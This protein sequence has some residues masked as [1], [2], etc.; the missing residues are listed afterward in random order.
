MVAYDDSM[1][2]KKQ[3]RLCETNERHTT[4]YNPRDKSCMYWL[5]AGEGDIAPSVQGVTFLGD[6][7]HK[8][9]FT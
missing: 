8:F 2:F 1:M 9:W 7:A 6:S 5:D 3:C 4:S